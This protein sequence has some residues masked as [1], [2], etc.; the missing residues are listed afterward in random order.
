MP[1]S[2]GNLWVD[3]R[4][5]TSAMAT[6]LR[7]ALRGAGAAA[8]DEA[9]ASLSTRLTQI[10]TSV[11][12]LGRQVSLGLS[13]PLIALGK[14]ATD[15]FTSFDTA[16][17]QVS[18]L[19][20][21]AQQDV[22]GWTD[23]VMALGHTYG[24]SATEAAQ[25]LYF[26][27]SA[28][29]SAS[30][31]MDVLNVA[32][33]S[34]AL[35]LG[36]TATTA[37]VVTS[38]INQYG[39]ENITAAHAADV[40]TVAVRTGKGE[41][42]ELAGALAKVIPLAGSMGVSFD[43]VAGVMSAMT[44]SGT[45]ADEAATQIN[46][47]LTSLQKMPAAN[48]RNM[49]A[50]TGLDYATV[51]NMLHNQGLTE[52][53]R[54]VYNAFQNNDD[55]IGKVFG[56][57]RA[58]RGI[59]NLFGE[60]EQQTLGVINQ[61]TH[62]VGAQD[63]AMQ[64]LAGSKAFQLKQAQADFSNAMTNIGGMVTPVVTQVTEAFAAVIG[65][66]QFL[67]GPLQTL[68]VG[69]GATAAAAGPLL[70]MGSSVMRLAGNIGTLIEKARGLSAVQNLGTRFQFIA[71]SMG[72]STAAGAKWIQMIKGAAVGAAAAGVAFEF[73]NAKIH[74]ND[75]AFQA[76]G[77]RGKQDLNTKSFDELGKVIERTNVQIQEYNQQKADLTSG[78]LGEQLPIFTGRELQDVDQAQRAIAAIGEKAAMV[79]GQAMALA[80][81]FH[82]SND[83]A[84]K[85][86]QTNAG[87]DGVF[88]NAA[89]AVD[90]YTKAQKENSASTRQATIDTDAAKHTLAG[91]IAASKETSD[92]FFGVVNAQKQYQAAQKAIADAKQ[93]VIDAEQAHKD[94]LQGVVDA[95][96][97]VADADRKVVEST[98]K[99]TDA[100]QELIDAQKRLNDLLA[101]PSKAEQLDLRSARL[102]VQE[103]QQGLRGKNM[104]PLERQRAQL[105]L[106]RAQLDLQDAQKAHDKAIAD[107]RKD[108]A[109]ATKG[110]AD[111]E[112]NRQDAIDAAAKAR[113]DLQTARDK[114]HQSLLDIKTA[115]DNVTQAYAD[116][117]GPAMGL[118]GAQSDLN[119]MFE[120]GTGKV[121]EFRDYLTRLK[122]LY[123]Q[124]AGPLQDYIDKFNALANLPEA[125]PPKPPEPPP[126]Q[127]PT[128]KAL[129]G[130]ITN[131]EHRTIPSTPGTPTPMGEGVYIPGVG[132]RK[133]AMGGPVTAGQLY[134]V[135]ERNIPELLMA[136]T[137]QFLLPVDSGKVVP[138]DRG[139]GVGGPTLNVAAINVYGADQP[140]QT[141]YEIRRQLR[142]KRD[143]VGRR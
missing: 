84:V 39:A 80:A 83:A 87:A 1:T 48:Q 123:P 130:S 61:T 26:I 2:V 19:S 108:V 93:K 76:A 126:T 17:T 12:N 62:A 78:V 134:E 138:L 66:V 40:L 137:R 113:A 11:G 7:G 77:E 8:G 124:L 38:A 20:G 55:A 4:F 89:A 132:Y 71:D 136:G 103:A 35:G 47:L 139:Q 74:E 42:D 70:Y 6:D 98:Q 15:T 105:T 24:V 120:T 54:T 110:V 122:D 100:R 63:E 29:I 91:V 22:Q 96:H 16:M 50:L 104:T 68:T 131:A 32:A 36:T 117:V 18:T 135:N 58:L 119:T 101:G 116:A 81:Q 37:D 127:S 82:I 133:R 13:L 56:N 75:A 114:E 28:G 44:L 90:A 109:S 64:K 88:K 111:A 60:K 121:D 69:L 95:Q 140:A 143:L 57:V 107:A 86:I 34:S 115:Q 97:K 67:P 73:V 112:Q 92:A 65:Q 5:D 72:L 10:G 53:L 43:E 25:G 9:T 94:A 79:R 141:A 85:W 128:V 3:V 46:A 52:T 51:Q 45:S 125:Q 31:A 23:D 33:K 27:T 99:V 59:T 118:T 49:K 106:E 102:A 21:V 14:Q 129:G 30:Q 41:A 142:A